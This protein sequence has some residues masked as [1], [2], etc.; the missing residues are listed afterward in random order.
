ML[1][2]GRM[3]MAI[4]FAL[5]TATAV[6]SSYVIRKS[7]AIIAIQAS[8]QAALQQQLAAAPSP[9]GNQGPSP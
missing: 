3:A 5:V 1:S 6:F 7:A 4:F 2:D 8:Q 9:Q